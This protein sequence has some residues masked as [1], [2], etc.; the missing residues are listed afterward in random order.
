MAPPHAFWAPVAS[1][2]PRLK[3]LDAVAGGIVKQD[4]LAAVSNDNVVNDVA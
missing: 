4:L 2:P 1:R 3:Q